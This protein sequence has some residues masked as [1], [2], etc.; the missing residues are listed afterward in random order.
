MSSPKKQYANI[1]S[2]SVNRKGVLDIDTFKGCPKGVAAHGER[3]CYGLCYAAKTAKFYKYEFERGSSRKVS[4]CKNVQQTLFKLPGNGGDESI[5]RLVKQHQLGWFRIGTMG[6]PCHDWELAAD[7]CEWLGTLKTPIIITKHWIV[8]RDQILRRLSKVGVIF[9]TSISALD[10]SDEIA[11][12]LAQYERVKSFGLKSVLRVVSCEFG[13]TENGLRMDEIQSELFSYPLVIDNPLRISA[14]DQRVLSGD[15]V[16]S[17]VKD[18]DAI[19]SI[20]VNNKN[21]YIGKCGDCP[22]QCGLTMKERRT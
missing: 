14:S 5:P 11:H 17:R 15:I 9:N 16:A 22:D 7:V 21:A 3:G 20:S 18:M 19:A 8:C 13:V 1:L 4:K 12:R 10:S 6:D 2:A